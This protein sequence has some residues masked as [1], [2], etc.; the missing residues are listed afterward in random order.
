MKKFFLSAFTFAVVAVGAVA[1]TA[2]LPTMVFSEVAAAEESEAPAT[3]LV[4]IIENSDME[5]TDASAFVVKENEVFVDNVIK[6]GVGKDSSRGVEVVSTP[7]AAEDWTTQFWIKM[8]E[9]IAAGKEITVSFDCKAT[10]PVSIG[11]QAHGEPGNYYHWECVGT[12]NFT[13]EWQTYKKTI[14]V[15]EA[16]A[17]STG[18]G[19]VAFNL[20]VD[21]A[22]EVRFYFDNI[23]VEMEKEVELDLTISPT[24]V[25]E[26]EENEY[27]LND[28][29]IVTVPG[30]NALKVG[31]GDNAAKVR[32]A[33]Y[34]INE[35]TE[36]E[37]WF[38]PGLMIPTEIEVASG[39]L[40]LNT[41][42]Y[43]EFENPLT[44]PT[45]HKYTLSVK[46]WDVD[47]ANLFDENFNMADPI[48]RFDCEFIGSADEVAIAMGQPNFGDRVISGM[49]I[50]VEA[51]NGL[52]ISYPEN[53]IA[54]ALAG[55]EALEYGAIALIVDNATLY[56]DGEEVA[57]EHYASEFE[58]S[59]V[60]VFTNEYLVA[61]KSYKVV[62]P[63][64]GLKLINQMEYDEES[65][66]LTLWA[67]TEAIEFSFNAT[68]PT[69]VVLGEPAFE[70]TSK[71]IVLTFPENNLAEACGEKYANG[72]INFA[73]IARLYNA[74]GEEVAAEVITGTT[75]E[76]VL[77]ADKLVADEAYTIKIDDNHLYV[78]DL[79]DFDYTAWDGKTAPGPTLN[80]NA[81]EIVYD[82]V[83][84]DSKEYVYENVDLT[85]E[86]FFQYNSN[87]TGE[88]LET[89]ATIGCDYNVGTST[90]MVYGLSTVKW[91]AY[92]DVTDYD[93]LVLEVTEGTPRVMYNREMNPDNA[94][95]DGINHVEITSESP[96]L[97]VEDLD[98]GAKLY[99]YDL[100]AMAAANPEKPFVHINAIKG[101]NWA[102]T[103]VTNMYLVKKSEKID[104]TVTLS[105]IADNDN[106][107]T[108]NDHSIVTIDAPIKAI[109]ATFGDLKPTEEVKYAIY[110]KRTPLAEGTMSVN[111][112]GYA[113]FDAPVTFYEGIQYY[114]AL[115]IGEDL[116]EYYVIGG[117]ELPVLA[118]GDYF[119]KNVATGKYLNGANAWGTK[120]SVTTHAQ[121]MTLAK[122]ED[123]T[124][125]IDSH[126][127]NGGDKHYVAAGDNTFLDALPAGHTIEEFAEGILSIKD[128]NGKY[129][130]TNND[131]TE[132]NFNADE[133]TEAAQWIFVTV[134]DVIAS[135][136]EASAKNPVDVTGLFGDANFGRNNQYIS[137]WDIQPGKG[138][139]N[140]NMNAEKWGGNSQEFDSHQTVALPNGIYKVSAQ[141]YYRY[142]N[143]TDNTNDIAAAAHADGTENINSYLYA[144]EVSVPLMSIADEATVE[145]NG[146]VM[147][148]S[149]AEASAAFGKGLYNNELTVEVTNGELTIGVKKIAHEGCDWTVW[150]NFEIYYLGMPE[151]L[152][153]G[154]VT[155]AA[156]DLDGM[157]V[158]ITDVA[159]K[160]TI[161]ACHTVHPAGEQDAFTLALDEY[162]GDQYIYAKLAKVNDA[163]VQGDNLYTIQLHNAAGQFYSLWGANGYLNFQPTGQNIVFV[164]GLTDKYGQDAE[165]CGLWEIT[166]VD[167]GYNV[168][169]VGNGGY[170]NP[171]EAVPSAEP[172]VVKFWENATADQG[173]VSAPEAT[174]I[175][176]VTTS[177]KP[178]G[179]YSVTGAK[180]AGLQ[181]GIN[182]VV[183]AN[184]VAKKV[185]LK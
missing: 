159:G 36:E 53:N 156:N 34:A 33:T 46:A 16:M 138:G 1:L 31:F 146:G 35:M 8:P 32:Y 88:A 168:K 48:A 87:T 59:T 103:T 179:I 137:S 66:P 166:E 25:V 165:N 161:T 163:S 113:E 43:V 148:F 11:T 39:K 89:P 141:G 135:M 177:A 97:T 99:T 104:T 158:V 94:D 26:G 15:S 144:N 83:A 49:D 14:T 115:T 154:A 17:S 64:G 79:S 72:E 182:I 73:G 125:T 102:N 122:L 9:P 170:Y 54:T 132:A 180:V 37:D 172:V 134:D 98:N 3:Q 116:R 133:V 164:L 174:A 50:N 7:G 27:A 160:N 107:Y 105:L 60:S 57:S 44:F 74:N 4:N 95:A 77:F 61:G 178:A 20:S 131:N 128:V 175:A 127:S 29:S 58:T 78:T 162:N 63:A 21:R 157:T 80:V 119:I 41:F 110:D 147:P 65:N 106:E 150:D 96:Y 82:F 90:G 118:E 169:N 117:V 19:S 140:T 68:T 111:T 93:K 184:G 38:T 75:P 126:I 112:I 10:A 153:A 183:D 24:F 100:K 101:A 62:I 22:N 114:I 56:A 47:E 84:V 6:D 130:A 23:K 5:G 151:P 86:M 71:G 76:F 145:A 18:L 181:K 67:S 28:H 139:D 92:A 81:E 142:N 2:N 152:V 52:T 13:T 143:T 55:N 40:E 173:A 42:G 136:A 69:E 129:L 109:K 70:N 149:Q 45:G 121:L 124:Y 155:K 120:A 123:G 51:W 30:A 12:V 167:G 185:V 108:V 171:C 91:F 176:T 85:N